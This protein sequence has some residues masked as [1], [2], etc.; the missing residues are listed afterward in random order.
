M[1]QKEA[2]KIAFTLRMIVDAADGDA[3]DVANAAIWAV[4]AIR[5]EHPKIGDTM[6]TM[7]D[8]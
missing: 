1:K 6:D 2:D 7:E 3:E 8:T 4:E 5:K